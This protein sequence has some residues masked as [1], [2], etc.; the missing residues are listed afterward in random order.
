MM[1]NIQAEQPDT[2]GLWGRAGRDDTRTPNAVGLVRTGVSVDTIHRTEADGLQAT[3]QLNQQH[4]IGIMFVHNTSDATRV[5]SFDPGGYPDLVQ[6]RE[7]LPKL[8]KLWDAVRHH[9]WTEA[10]PAHRRSHPSETRK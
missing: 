5:A 8:A 7:R 1:T 10:I 4:E 6:A 3:W 2:V 9:F